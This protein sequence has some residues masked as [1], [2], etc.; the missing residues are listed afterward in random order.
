MRR[1]AA[2]AIPTANSGGRGV[3]AGR[4]GDDDAGPIRGVEVDVDRAAAAHRDH[5]QLRP[6]GEHPRGEGGHLG[7]ADAGPVEGVDE[8]LLGARGLR[9]HRI[10]GADRPEGLGGPAGG[11][12]GDVEAG[13][14]GLVAQG[15]LEQGRGDEVVACGQHA[16]V[17]GVA[18][19]RVH[20]VSRAASGPARTR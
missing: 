17:G 11:E 19:L 10:P 15:G 20:G 3:A 7:Q 2:S 6:G 9:H 8:L 16:R 4:L 14:A 1:S 5:L 12:V 13:Q 18:A